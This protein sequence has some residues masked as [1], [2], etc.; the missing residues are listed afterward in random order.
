MQLV[1]RVPGLQ[2]AQAE[3]GQDVAAADDEDAQVEQVEQ[4]RQPV[5]NAAMSRTVATTRAW[6]RRITD[7]PGG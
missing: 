1:H 7:A 3:T 4:E 5:E 2:V 6:T